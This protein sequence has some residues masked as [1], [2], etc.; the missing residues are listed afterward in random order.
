MSRYLSLK[1][2]VQA[3]WTDTGV[4]HTYLHFSIRGAATC[5]LELFKF[6]LIKTKE[7]DAPVALA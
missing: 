7:I 4:I 5:H 2:E 6:K 3:R 1:E